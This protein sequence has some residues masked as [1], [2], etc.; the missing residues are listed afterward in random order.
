MTTLRCDKCGDS[1]ASCNRLSA[2]LAEGSPMATISR[3]GHPGHD[4]PGP[5]VPTAA[6]YH[7][8]LDDIHRQLERVIGLLE[9]AARDRAEAEHGAMC[10]RSGA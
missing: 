10:R 1:L 2:A 9:T 7:K 5:A 4:V 8:S 6:G 3:P